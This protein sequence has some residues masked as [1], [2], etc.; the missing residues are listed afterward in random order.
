MAGRSK[1][2]II[3]GGYTGAAAAIHLSRMAGR[4]LDIRIIEPRE[5]AGRGVAYDT[6]DPAHRLNV[7]PVP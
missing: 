2:V 7:S 3:G 6:E 4:P 1:V 5:D